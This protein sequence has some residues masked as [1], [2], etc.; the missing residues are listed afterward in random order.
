M[1]LLRPTTERVIAILKSIHPQSINTLVLNAKS[2]NSAHYW[3]NDGN[4]FPPHFYPEQPPFVFYLYIIRDG[5]V[6][7]YSDVYSGNVKL[8]QSACSH[9]INTKPPSNV[10]RIPMHDEIFSI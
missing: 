3:P 7:D 4:A 6:M 8:V 1:T 5:I 10:H 2:V 9:H